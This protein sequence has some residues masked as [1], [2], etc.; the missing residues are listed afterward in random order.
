MCSSD[1]K[2]PGTRGLHRSKV[3]KR[4]YTPRSSESSQTNDPALGGYIYTGVN[5][6]E[7]SHTSRQENS[8]KKSGSLQNKSAGEAGINKSTG[9]VGI[10]KSAG[11][12]GID[13]SAGEAGIDDSANIYTNN[14]GTSTSTTRQHLQLQPSKVYIDNLANPKSGAA[15]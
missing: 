5:K 13:K 8:E 7:Q 2:Q 15:T 6:L 4:S 11:E 1:L 9:E 3:K 10:N 12:A 14:P